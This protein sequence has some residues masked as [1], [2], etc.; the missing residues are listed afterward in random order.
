MTK[1]TDEQVD[2]LRHGTASDV[3]RVAAD[4]V[5]S[6]NPDMSDSSLV[7][8]ESYLTS[9]MAMLQQQESFR[10]RYKDMLFRKET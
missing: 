6:L 7:I 2:A 10:E 9:V 3:V 1:L 5:E 4:F 8:L